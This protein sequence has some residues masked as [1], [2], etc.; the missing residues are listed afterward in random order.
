[1]SDHPEWLT[2]PCPFWCDRNHQRQEHPVD[3]THSSEH[4]MV[5]VIV[6]DRTLALGNGEPAVF[7]DEFAIFA[8]RHVRDPETWVAIASDHQHIEVS[9]ES[10]ERLHRKLEAVL[11]MLMSI[12]RPVADPS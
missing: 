7:A 2:E 10:A 5:P 3:R 12:P 11:S 8:L 6:H 4:G 9:V 1:M